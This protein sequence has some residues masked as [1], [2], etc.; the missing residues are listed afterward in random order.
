[1]VQKAQEELR[2]LIAVVTELLETQQETLGSID[3]NADEQ[4]TARQAE[5]LAQI[6]RRGII[7]QPSCS[8]AQLANTKLKRLQA[9]LAAAKSFACALTG[10]SSV[11]P[12]VG[13]FSAIQELLDLEEKAVAQLSPADDETAI[14][15]ERATTSVIASQQGLQQVVCELLALCGALDDRLWAYLRLVRNM[16]LVL[17]S[18][19]AV[20]FLQGLYG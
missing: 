19:P 11:A 13:V 20:D 9:Y 10:V 3:T 5:Q 18:R 7:S 15:E 8:L 16:K 6:E 17:E 14:A 12:G 1:M 4:T 2:Q